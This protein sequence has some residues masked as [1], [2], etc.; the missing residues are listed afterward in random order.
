MPTDLS[1]FLPTGYDRNRSVA[2]IAGNGVY[3]QLTTSALRKQGIPVRL[4]G[5]EGETAPE[6]IESFPESERRIMHVGQL[7]RMLK[8]LREFE[9][10]YAIM[11]GQITPRRLFHGLRP[12]LKT[13]AILL[14]LKKKNAE[15]IFG[16]I[17]EEIEG[18]QVG[19]MDARAFLDDHLALDGP[20]TTGRMK[21]DGDT[22]MH[23]VEIAREVARLDI[24]Q[25]VV[26]R[27]G[28][29]VA[30]E[31]FEGTDEMLRRAGGFK[32]D[33]MVFVKTVKPR[34][35]FR[36]DVPVFGHRTLETMREAS[37]EVAVLEAGN[38]LILERESVLAQA[39]SWG[40][41]LIGFRP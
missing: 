3:P 41:H 35:D 24:G 25:G 17:A 23:G 14:R 12:D 22:I 37:I 40:I 16:A 33:G 1:R 20:M 2:V 13:A 39:N 10:G 30:V 18:I 29:V 32:T 4:V 31:A 11:A 21:V 15:T 26:V 19:L 6:L 27:K 9:A 5:F 38:T 34:Q 7:G 28:T 36:F 8:A